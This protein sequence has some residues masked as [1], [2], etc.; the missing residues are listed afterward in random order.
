MNLITSG[1]AVVPTPPAYVPYHPARFLRPF[2][3]VRESGG[4]G[5]GREEARN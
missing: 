5:C 1:S 2:D 3:A 4:R